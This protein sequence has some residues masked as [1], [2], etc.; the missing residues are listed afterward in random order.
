M[1]FPILSAMSDVNGTVWVSALDAAIKVT[2]LLSAAGVVTWTLGRASAALRH[3]VWTLALV[4]ALALPMLSIA[5]PRWQLPIVTLAAPAPAPA[6]AP[7]D[8][9][10]APPLSRRE[11]TPS[12]AIE[13]GPPAPPDASQSVTRIL[14]GMSWS[15]WLL[16]IWAAG[17]AAILGRLFVGLIAVQWMS[18]RTEAVVDAPWLPLYTRLHWVVARPEVRN[19]RLHPS[20]YHRLD[21]VFGDGA[22]R[23]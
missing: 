18:R 6:A 3:L 16:A 8:A 19:L 20:G 21:R 12:A 9:A 7:E 22:A 11:R 4:S 15:S 14:G 1:S 13:S 10:Q 5:L 17:V 2:L 23:P